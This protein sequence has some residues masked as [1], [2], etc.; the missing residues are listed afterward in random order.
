MS[1]SQYDRLPGTAR[2]IVDTDR[3]L[4]AARNRTVLTIAEAREIRET[5]KDRRALRTIADATWG[6]PL[7]NDGTA[8]E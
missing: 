2:A 4:A 8:R 3:S 7:R 1:P 5:V 6:K